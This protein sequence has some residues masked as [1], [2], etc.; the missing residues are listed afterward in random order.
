MGL[1]FAHHHHQD[2]NWSTA[3]PRSVESWALAAT[4]GAISD[5]HVDAAGFGTWVR[6]ILG[7]KIWYIGVNRAAVP[8]ADG[9]DKGSLEWHAI[10][11][12]PQDEL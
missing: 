6:L 9:W 4:A 5:V 10:V 12:G 3:E 2:F 8:T 7:R 11:L 1:Q